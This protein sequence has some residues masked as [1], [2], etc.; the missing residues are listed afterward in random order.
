[1]VINDST[2]IGCAT[3]ATSCPYQNIHM[4]NIRDGNG[5]FI[6]DEATQTPIAKATKCDFCVEQIGGPA[7]VNACP[8]DAMA[9]VDMS[10]IDL[11]SGWIR[12]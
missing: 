12:R 9:R 3:C 8:H 4:V 10:D 2:C 5:S 6:L 1:I 7:C 11:L